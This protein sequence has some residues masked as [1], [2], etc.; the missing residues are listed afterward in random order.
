M[1]LIHFFPI[2][3]QI[4]LITSRHVVPLNSHLLSP[5]GYK[6]NNLKSKLDAPPNQFPTQF[7]TYIVQKLYIKKNL[8]QHKE[9]CLRFSKY[10][11]MT[12]QPEDGRREVRYCDLHNLFFLISQ[13]KRMSNTQKYLILVPEPF[14]QIMLQLLP[15]SVQHFTSFFAIHQIFIKNKRR[16]RFIK[17]SKFSQNLRN[18]ILLALPKIFNFGTFFQNVLVIKLTST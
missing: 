9:S 8:R 6:Q 3:G 1:R 14:F 5:N 15:T 4:F 10:L 2:K 7:I 12:I 16:K 17:Y 18:P 11:S 13:T